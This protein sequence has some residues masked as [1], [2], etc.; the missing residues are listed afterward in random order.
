[1]KIRLLSQFS[2][3]N[4]VNPAYCGFN[5]QS[6]K[7]SPTQPL[8]AFGMGERT[9]KAKLRKPVGEDKTS[10]TAKGEAACASQAQ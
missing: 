3:M 7:L 2:K 9:G 5:P 6:R 1:M 8:T 10:S 4:E